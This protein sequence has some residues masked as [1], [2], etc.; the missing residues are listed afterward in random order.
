MRATLTFVCAEFTRPA[1]S[2]ICF[3]LLPAAAM[4]V[5]AAISLGNVGV[6]K[7]CDTRLKELVE[8][9]EEL[10]LVFANGIEPVRFEKWSDAFTTDVPIDAT[11]R[12][13]DILI[14]ICHSRAAAVD[15][16]CHRDPGVGY[17]LKNH[18]RQAEITVDQHE[19]LIGGNAREQVDEYLVCATT[20]PLPIE[21]VLPHSPGHDLPAR[22]L[23]LPLVAMIEWAIADVCAMQARQSMPE[24][25]CHFQ[26]AAVPMGVR[27]VRTANSFCQQILVAVDAAVLANRWHEERVLVHPAQ[28]LIFLVEA[29]LRSEWRHFEIESRQVLRATAPHRRA[30]LSDADRRE[31][32]PRQTSRNPDRNFHYRCTREEAGILPNLQRSDGASR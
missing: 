8:E 23:D 25:P 18:V 6:E 7:S 27:S 14:A 3:G 12:K 16:T 20:E 32:I 5:G 1:Y 24:R 2:S 13:R 22:L 4:T 29:R 19:I 11:Y 15:Q 10:D 21:F 30:G 26:G 17:L 31:Q 9:H 28:S